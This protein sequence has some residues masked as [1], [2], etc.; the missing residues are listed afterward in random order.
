MVRI[1]RHNYIFMPALHRVYRL[2][3]II[4]CVVV[5]VYIIVIIIMMMLQC[6]KVIPDKRPSFEIII[7]TPPNKLRE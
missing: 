3:D 2:S 5:F 7:R 1:S 6:W 4:V